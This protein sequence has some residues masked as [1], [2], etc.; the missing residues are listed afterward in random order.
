MCQFHY[1]IIFVRVRSQITYLSDLFLT[2]YE[3]SKRC[4]IDEHYACEGLSLSKVQFVSIDVYD[5]CTVEDSIID[6]VI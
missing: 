2:R 3:G 5:L 1:S 6:T 4:A